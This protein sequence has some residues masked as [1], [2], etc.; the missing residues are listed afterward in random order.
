VHVRGGNGNGGKMI[1]TGSAIHHCR[2]R[3]AY[4]DFL[5][6]RNCISYSLQR[7]PAIF[8]TW[9]SFFS[10]AFLH[11]DLILGNGDKL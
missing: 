4:L 2:A 5:S 9:S 1:S 10:F 6:L 7:S 3:L 8:L 11:G